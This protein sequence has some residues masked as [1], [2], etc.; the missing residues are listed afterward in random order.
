[1]LIKFKAT[2]V[3]F[4]A[5]LHDLIHEDLRRVYPSLIHHVN[6]TIYDVAPKI[7]PMFDKKLAEYAL[8][9]FKRDGIQV[10]TEH[11]IDSLTPGAPGKDREQFD[12]GVFT[13]KTKQNGEIG[14][15]MCVWST[16]QQ[17]LLVFFSPY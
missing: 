16:G 4:A 12:G 7:L 6:I 3:E 11:N 1:L 10:R 2:G 14:V 8:K 17:L 5:E 9:L 15:G 13:L